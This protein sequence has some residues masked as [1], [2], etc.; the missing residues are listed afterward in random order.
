[1]YIESAKIENIKSVSTLS[2][3]LGSRPRAG[4]HVILGDNASGKTSF[5]RAVAMA[6]MG[7]RDADLAIIDWASY[8]QLGKD[9]ASC[10]LKVLRFPDKINPSSIYSAGE[11]FNFVVGTG[12][13]LRDGKTKT[14][15]LIGEDN[16]DKTR[17]LDEENPGLLYLSIMDDLFSVAYGPQRRFTGGNRDEE[18]RLMSRPITGRHMSLFREDISL[19]QPIDWLRSLRGDELETREPS[20]ALRNVTSFINQKDFLPNGVRLHSVSTKDVLFED[21]DHNMISI[22]ELSDGYRSVLCLTL[23]LLRQ[24]HLTFRPE[25]VPELHR[26]IFDKKMHQVIL[27]GI[28]LVDEVDIHLHPSWQRAIG[29]WFRKH[30]P[31]MQFIVTSHSPLVCQAA[32]HG[33]VFALPDPEAGGEGGFVEGSTLDRLLYGDILDSY[34]TDLFGGGITRSEVAQEKMDR[35]ATL[36]MKALEKGLSAK[37]RQEQA[38][39]QE[40]FQSNPTILSHDSGERL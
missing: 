20:V 4:W 6:L 40:I 25:R 30:F 27:P 35:L 17:V 36:N 33:S 22:T 24:L 3:D 15:R 12:I 2:W 23:E 29:P 32:E 28:V 7:P 13:E 16:V 21:S 9:S 18:T 31:N 26:D 5:L 1:M 38:S 39:L 37:E 34:S 11:P 10:I 8:V 19:P 14:R